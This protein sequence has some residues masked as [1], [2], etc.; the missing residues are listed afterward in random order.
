ML[1]STNCKIVVNKHPKL[2]N[3]AA[4]IVEDGWIVEMEIPWDMLDYPEATEPI[5]IGLTL[6]AGT[7]EQVL[8]HGGQKSDLVK[9]TEWTVIG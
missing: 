7:Q 3:V 6:T 9:I 4:N 2:W 8:T 1:I 5:D